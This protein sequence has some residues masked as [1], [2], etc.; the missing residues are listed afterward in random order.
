M[1]KI[2]ALIKRI[3]SYG[4]AEWVFSDYPI[5]IKNQDPIESK[6][7]GRLQ[8]IPWTAQIINWWQMG[9][10]GNSK[11]EALENLRSNFESFRQNHAELPRPG[12]GLP[13]EFA[14]ADLVSKYEHLAG[15]FFD[16]IL[17]LNYDECIISD[18]S[19]LWDFHSEESNATYYKKIESKYGIDVSDIEDGNLVSIFQRINENKNSS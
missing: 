4:K 8:L 5:R 6:L 15:D 14:S 12:T 17:D 9:G 16:K 7:G 13:I 3:A 1:D 19:S 11:E 10:H 2:R 18:E